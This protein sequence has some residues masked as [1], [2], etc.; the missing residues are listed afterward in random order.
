MDERSSGNGSIMRL[1]PVPTRY[2]KLFP[3]SIDEPARLA[4]ESSLTTHA[5]EHCC[6][7]CRYMVLVLA[8]LLHGI[9]R[10]EVFAPDW[11]PLVQL[12]LNLCR[13]SDTIPHAAMDHE[14]IE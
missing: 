7:A 3:D 10:D 5:S 2:V 13:P 11:R 14:R 6:S 12:L 8:G 9:D 1:A 4:T